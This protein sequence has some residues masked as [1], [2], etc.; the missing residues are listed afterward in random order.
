MILSGELQSR[1]HAAHPNLTVVEV[2]ARGIR[3]LRAA[4]VEQVL[5]AAKATHHRVLLVVR[6][7]Q[8][9]HA[10]LRQE[11][12]AF[13]AVLQPALAQRLAFAALGVNGTTTAPPGVLTD[14]AARLLAQPTTQPLVVARTYRWDRKRFEVF[15][16]LFDAWLTKAGPLSITSLSERAGVSYPTVSVTLKALESRGEVGRTR[17]RSVELVGLPR[18]SLAELVPRL[19]ELRETHVYVDGSGRGASPESILLRL[20]HKKPP[21][22]QVG[23]VA[24]ARQSWPG[25]NLNGLPRIDATCGWGLA[26]GW[27]Q[28]IDAALQRATT[29]SPQVVLAVHHTHAPSRPDDTLWARPGR[30]VFDLFCLGLSEQAEDFIRH[31]RP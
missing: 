31:L 26:P 29:S 10:R 30:V 16:E 23:G 28:S 4:L 25:F 19:T 17:S 18:T 6:A 15:A 13:T 27:V 2:E 5:T 11:W 14:D 24:A 8:M 22:V 9:T 3:E 7:P 1:L 21:G 20:Q 12:D